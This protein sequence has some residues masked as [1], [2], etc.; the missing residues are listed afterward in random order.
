[1]IKRLSV[2]SVVALAVLTSHQ[3][4]HAQDDADLPNPIVAANLGS[5]ARYLFELSHPSRSEV[6]CFEV[7]LQDRSADRFTVAEI[8]TRDGMRGPTAEV[9]Y[10]IASTMKAQ[11]LA[12][13]RAQF[14]D[15]VIKRTTVFDG[16]THV[17]RGVTYACHRMYVEMEGTIQ[18][19]PCSVDLCYDVHPD[20]GP[21]GIVLFRSIVSCRTPTTKTQCFT[22][23][24]DSK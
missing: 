7:T 19:A 11:I 23:R 8:L 18:E 12:V 4:A 3:R 1:M 6:G 21:L 5:T 9:S 2:F 17:V 16:I 24:L 10:P 14:Q 13:Y 22:M 15:L 20:A